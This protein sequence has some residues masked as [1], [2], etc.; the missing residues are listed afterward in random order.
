MNKAGLLHHV[1]IY[2]DNLEATKTFWGWFLDRLGYV[3]YQEWDA[4]ISYQKGETYLVFVQ[5]EEK[6]LIP[7]YHRCHSG[8][9][10]LAF[11]A[12][13]RDMVD[14]IT[15]ELRK[16]GITILYEDRHPYASGE[17]AYAVFFEDPMRMKVELCAY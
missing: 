13:S 9:N 8:L 5:T 11:H 4:G 7:K 2:V 14:A 10:H 16:R 15:D 6:Y 3:T 1:E 12:A 17:D